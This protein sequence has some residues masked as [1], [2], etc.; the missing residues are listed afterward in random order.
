MC[1]KNDYYACRPQQGT[2]L[3]YFYEVFAAVS[4]SYQVCKLLKSTTVVSS[5]LK[6]LS[7]CI[8]ILYFGNSTPFQGFFVSII[9]CFINSDVSTSR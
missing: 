2:T 7:L 6:A 4:S 1:T 8:L 5:Q 9:F 3:E